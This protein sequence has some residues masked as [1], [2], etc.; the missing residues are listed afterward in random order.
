MKRYFW[1]WIIVLITSISF[2]NC[3][4]DDNYQ[5]NGNADAVAQKKEKFSKAFVGAFGEIA[6]GQTWGFE[7]TPTTGV[8]PNDE[9]IVTDDVT[10]ETIRSYD[11]DKIIEEE[12]IYDYS[13]YYEDLNGKKKRDISKT[14]VQHKFMPHYEYSFEACDVII[15]AGRVFCENLASNYAY[16]ADNPSSKNDFDFNDIVF[17]AYIIE[18]T[19]IRKTI[20]SVLES[21]RTIVE[22]YTEYI[23]KTEDTG[24]AVITYIEDSNWGDFQQYSEVTP[25]KTKQLNIRKD[26]DTLEGITV[27]PHIFAKVTL[28]A[29]GGTKEATILG[30]EV[31]GL[32]NVTVS[33]MV[34]SG[35]GSA[36]SSSGNVSK[37]P[38]Q[39]T[40]SHIAYDL[41]DE[42]DIER[43]TADDYAKGDDALYSG[44]T[45]SSLLFGGY[46]TIINI[47]VL[48][49]FDDKHVCSLDTEKG[50]AP[51]KIAMQPEVIVTGLK[52]KTYAAPWP[53]ENCSIDLA[54]EDFNKTGSSQTVATWTD[55]NRTY[56]YNDADIIACEAKGASHIFTASGSIASTI[57]TT[58]YDNSKDKGHEGGYDISK[59]MTF[60]N[61][62]DIIGMLNEGDIIQVTGSVINAEKTLAVDETKNWIIY[63]CDGNANSLAE[64]K[65]YDS[66]NVTATFTI[67]RSILAKLR[68]NVSGQNAI[69]LNGENLKVMTV[70]IVRTS[71]SG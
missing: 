45:S 9:Y 62:S 27:E 58:L 47:P 69:I 63:L 59:G 2:V 24:D 70:S 15:E 7:Y 21:S 36:L 26:K 35:Y 53:I 14:I 1:G 48:V 39:L 23:D 28:V 54:Y 38:V 17:D 65:G 51:L 10:G 31:H 25:Y 13:N 50:E 60:E 16:S 33:T 12:P 11:F 46:K 57:I 61:V 67:S 43:K 4:H 55:P 64:D 52:E 18:R 68:S 20:A 71:V 40:N 5:S 42:F 3:R 29:A 32:F 49:H 66:N 56:T 6:S 37:D 8:I 22:H 19:Y 41:N 44:I 30:E 34:N